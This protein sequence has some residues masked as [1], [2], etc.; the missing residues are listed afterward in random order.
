M[1]FI[2]LKESKIIEPNTQIVVIRLG[3]IKILFEGSM[4]ACKTYGFREIDS[5]VPNGNELIIRLK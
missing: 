5:I 3:D 4:Y 2:K 1:K